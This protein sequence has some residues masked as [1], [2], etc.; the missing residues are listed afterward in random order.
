MSAYATLNGERV[1]KGQVVIPRHGAWHADLVLASPVAAN[2]HADV[3]LGNLS[4]KAT[5]FRALSWAGARGIRVTSG[6]GWSKDVP[7]KYY[8]GA[9]TRGIVVGDVAR[10]VGE[11]AQVDV[12][13]GLGDAWV[14]EAG[15]AS[16]VL[17]LAAGEWFVR[18][19]G[20]TQIGKRTPKQI[21]TP[22][23]LTTVEGAVGRIIVGT[24]DIASWQPDNT[25]TPPTIRQQQTI[26]TVMHTIADGVV[27]T[28]VLTGASDTDR[29]RDSL[30]AFVRSID[31]GKTFQGLYEYV[32]VSQDDDVVSGRPSDPS[33]G[34]PEIVDVPMVPSI[35]GG[36][37]DLPP[38][39]TVIVGFINGSPSRPRVLFADIGNDP[40]TLVFAGSRSSAP[41]VI[42]VGDT[43][44]VGTA[45][46]AIA[47]SLPNPIPGAKLR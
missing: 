38:G 22:Y 3:V 43:V 28:E 27:R 23:T 6:A 30:A 40:T 44:S 36:H 10:E 37:V 32:V 2:G 39:S 19:D 18:P 24:E 41:K 45:A 14:R 20:V 31:P 46:G 35:A 15:P 12:D 11:T 29:L 25:F 42:R 47:L 26:S 8:K 9:V 21:T 16:R 7:P 4:L 1:V 13:A 34:L 5:R 17:D 33:I